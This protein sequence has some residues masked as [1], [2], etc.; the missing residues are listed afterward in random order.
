MVTIMQSNIETIVTFRISWHQSN[1][2]F[3]DD[4]YFKTA[5]IEFFFNVLYIDI[6]EESMF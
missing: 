5:H 3:E 1:S 2:L 6:E 4:W